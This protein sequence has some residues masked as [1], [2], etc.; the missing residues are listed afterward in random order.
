MWTAK[1]PSI[2]PFHEALRKPPAKV[3]QILPQ[4]QQYLYLELENAQHA[5]I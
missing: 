4:D 1:D 5:A 2:F 3:N